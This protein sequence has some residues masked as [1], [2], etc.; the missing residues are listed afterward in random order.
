MKSKCSTIQLY[1]IVNSDQSDAKIFNYTKCPQEM[2]IS[3]I[4]IEGTDGIT[5]KILQ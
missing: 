2:L 3:C 5:N 1:S 4:T